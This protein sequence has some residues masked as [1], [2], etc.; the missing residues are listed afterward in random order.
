[1]EQLALFALPMADE[2]E[3]ED[4]SVGEGSDEDDDIPLDDKDVAISYPMQDRLSA[5]AAENISTKLSANNLDVDNQTAQQAWMLRTSVIHTL[6]I[7]PM[8]EAELAL[9]LPAYVPSGTN[10]LRQAL[11]KV[12]YWKKFTSESPGKWHLKDGFYKELDVWGF[13]YGDAKER[14]RAIDNAIKQY[15]EMGLRSDE[16]QWQRLLPEADRGTGKSLPA[17]HESITPPR[18]EITSNQVREDEIIALAS[19]YGEDFRERMSSVAGW[20]SF[21]VRIKSSDEEIWATLEV[22]LPATYPNAEPLLRIEDD[23]GLREET[24]KYLRQIVDTKPKELVVKGQPMIM[25]IVYAC[26]EVLQDAVEAKATSKETGKPETGPYYG[27]MVRGAE[28][29][30]MKVISA[31]SKDSGDMTRDNPE[32]SWND[33]S[34]IRD[35]HPQSPTQ[36]PPMGFPSPQDMDRTQSRNRRTSIEGDLPD[37]ELPPHRVLSD[38][39]RHR[40]SHANPRHYTTVEPNQN[41]VL[42]NHTMSRKWDACEILDICSRLGGTIHCIGVTMKG[43][44]CR[45][46]ISWQA[47]KEIRTL[48]LLLETKPPDSN[49]LYPFLQ[50]LAPLCLCEKFHQRQTQTVIQSW[51]ASIN[52]VSKPVDDLPFSSL[53]PETRHPAFTR[54]EE[55]NNGLSSKTAALLSPKTKEKLA[56]R[57][58]HP[59]SVHELPPDA[60]QPPESA[61]TSIGSPVSVLIQ[62]VSADTTEDTLR[63]MVNWS[64]S[65]IDATLLSSMKFD[66]PGFRS[67]LLRFKTFQG[68]LEAKNRLDGTTNP[69]DSAWMIV[70]ILSNDDVED[71]VRD[72]LAEV[73]AP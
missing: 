36:S 35:G 59:V 71:L 45:W 66:N 56:L 37:E 67:A 28:K 18:Q 22:I 44:R 68:A 51:I 58:S 60:S 2:D 46:N 61:S 27:R 34:T 52:T 6:A 48:I 50:T 32:R 9:K 16:P 63:S 14:Q 19:I 26:L 11:Q 42:Q 57:T 12:A 62:R 17:S 41:A 39:A 38:T 1:M 3:M 55:S 69:D 72:T 8:T 49:A 23:D 40:S 64:N 73:A 43:T 53:S 7:E 24:R 30:F 54:N 15:D 13:P 25:E 5:A 10:E 4:D 65:F 20:K 33:S 47:C 31:Y 29:L 70:R 21:D